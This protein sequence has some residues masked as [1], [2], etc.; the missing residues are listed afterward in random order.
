MRGEPEVLEELR[1]Y[2]AR[3][4]IIRPL[5]PFVRSNQYGRAE[6]VVPDVSRQSFAARAQIEDQISV[7]AGSF[8][9][10]LTGFTDQTFPND[11][12]FTLADKGSG[13][14]YASQFTR[15]QAATG[16]NSTQSTVTAVQGRTMPLIVPSPWIVTEPGLVAVRIS[17]LATV[18][19]VINLCLVFAIPRAA[20]RIR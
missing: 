14:E 1:V 10:M 16:G 12:M 6:F 2:W 7:P 5:L 8:L 17:N 13:R 20:R 9:I 4:S 3:P 18:S 11:F 15:Y 19:A